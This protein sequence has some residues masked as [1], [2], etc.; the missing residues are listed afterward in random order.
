MQ[1]RIG[2]A[3]MPSTSG[4]QSCE[5]IGRQHPVHVCLSR[6]DQLLLVATGHLA[7]PGNPHKEVAA[8]MKKLQ[9]AWQM[10]MALWLRAL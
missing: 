6:I 8:S 10:W 2:N 5:Y 3:T 4:C 1:A 9:Q 7:I